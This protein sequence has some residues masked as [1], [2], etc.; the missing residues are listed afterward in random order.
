MNAKRRLRYKSDIDECKNKIE[1]LHDQ[2]DDY[3]CGQLCGYKNKLVNLLVQEE[4]F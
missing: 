3:S 1:A 4:I 2:N